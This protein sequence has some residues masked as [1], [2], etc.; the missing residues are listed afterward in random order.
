MQSLKQQKLFVVALLVIG[1]LLTGCSSG[2]S[3]TVERFFRAT[4]DG[5]Q[6]EA[7]DLLSSQVIATFGRD[8]LIAG[9]ADRTREIESLGGIDSIAT[10]ETI[11]GDSASVNVTVTY[12]DGSVES[13]R[14]DLIKEDGD[15]KIT[16]TK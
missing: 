2:P 12:G 6:S 11:N 3:R 8:K 4:E 10:D 5:K 13:D 16:A 7:V 9:L 14:V 1:I 15:W